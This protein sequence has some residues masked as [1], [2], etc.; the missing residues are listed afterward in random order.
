[1]A[2]IRV[3][4]KR[5]GGAKW[6]VIVLLLLALA[7]LAYWWFVVNGGAATTTPDATD[8]ARTS[9]AITHVIERAGGAWRAPALT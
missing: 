8:T 6:L 9:S 2:E 5:G 4:P 3:E 1:M 7:A